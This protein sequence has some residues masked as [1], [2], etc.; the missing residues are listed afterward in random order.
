MLGLPSASSWPTLEHLPHWRDNTENVRAHKLEY[1]TKSRLADV[2]A[3]YR[4]AAAAT[5]PP[6][7]RG[8]QH[9]NMMQGHMGPACSGV[10]AMQAWIEFERR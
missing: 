9:M 4:R 7:S 6:T 3:E 2:I 5:R 10:G 8:Y 1:P